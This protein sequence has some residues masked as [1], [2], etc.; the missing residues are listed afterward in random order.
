VLPEAVAKDPGRLARF[1]REAKA[2][3]KLA[4]PNILEIHELGEHEGRPF[5][6]TELLEGETLRGRLEGATLGWRKAAE[7]GAC[8]ADGLAAAHAAGIVHRDLKPSNVFLTSDGRVKILDFGLARHAETTGQGETHAPTVTR[9]T[10]P[11]TVLGTVGYMSPE[12]VS[13]A[14]TDHRSDIFSLGCVLYEMAS[15]RRAFAGDTAVETMNAILKEEPPEISSTDA[16]LPSEL[17]RNIRR[18]LEK[19]PEARYQS[20]SDLAY[21]LRSV[22]SASAPSVGFLGTRSIGSRRRPSWTLIIALAVFGAVAALLG[23]VFLSPLLGTVADLPTADKPV[24]RA[25]LPLGPE[26]RL[27]PRID[28]PIAMGNPKI[29]I[30]PDG[31][32]LAYV[33]AFEGSTRI[34]LRSLE[35]AFSTPLAGTEG[36]F[37]P[38]F[39]PGGQWIGF[40]TEDRLK[41]LAIQGGAPVVLCTTHDPVGGSWGEDGKIV[42]A[43]LSGGLQRVADSGGEVEQLIA[44]DFI[45]GIWCWPQV[46]QGGHAILL[47]IWKFPSSPDYWKVGVFLP[48]TGELRTLL[49]GGF[50]A[51]ALSTGHLVFARGSTLYAAP[52][53]G[54]RLTVSGEPVQVVEGVQTEMR[55][56]AQFSYR[57]T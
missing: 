57:L 38:F 1:E 50:F 36:G 48:E 15:G 21:N 56:S 51:R 12:Q 25:V 53:D 14:E 47:T 24:I 11:G 30:S 45:K 16:P 54:D 7:I 52:F 40:F 20:A 4:H 13:G 18:C 10:E 37:D 26:E 42:F 19:R 5:M 27:A 29:A 32:L 28:H 8:L 46:L 44:A 6:A 9:Q 49:E 3:A 33:E 39:S 2:I 55:G 17:E 43:T 41:K 35:E 22:A 31:S 34:R 23:G